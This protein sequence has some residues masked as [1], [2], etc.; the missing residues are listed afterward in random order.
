MMFLLWTFYSYYL[1]TEVRIIVSTVGFDWLFI[2]IYI[3][4]A[5][6]VTHTEGF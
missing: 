5:L 4:A 2:F 3:W 6:L 1:F